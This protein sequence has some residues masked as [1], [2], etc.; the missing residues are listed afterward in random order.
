MRQVDV[1]SGYVGVD[2]GGGVKLAVTRI[3]GIQ[4]GG[5]E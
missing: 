5:K 3:G 2:L 4:G 1:A